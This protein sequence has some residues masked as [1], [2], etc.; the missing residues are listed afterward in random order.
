MS[1]RVTDEWRLRR[2]GPSLS[3]GRVA[4]MATAPGCPDGPHPTRH[5]ECASFRSMADAEAY[6]AKKV[7]S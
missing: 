2:T 7:T 4:V 3:F 1:A 5:C 6:V